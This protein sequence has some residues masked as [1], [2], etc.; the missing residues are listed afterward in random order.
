MADRIVPAFKRGDPNSAV[1]DGA[2]GLREL[3][4]RS[5]INHPEETISPV[6]VD[7]ASGEVV[8]ENTASGGLELPAHVTDNAPWYLGGGAGTL[9]AGGMGVRRWL[10]RRPRICPDCKQP[11][12]LLDE[13]EDD[14]H[15]N[16]GERKEETIGSVDYDVW[17]CGECQ[18]V[19]VERYGAW[20]T[21]YSKCPSCSFKTKK[22]STRT[23]VSATYDHGGSV[24]V[25]VTCKNCPHCSSFTRS[26]P[27]LTR[28]STTSSSSS[29]S[30]FGGGR[31]SG[32]GSS[33]GW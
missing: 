26:T 17:W 6:P 16:D 12:K 31:S 9:F 33:G 30:S 5:T 27:R 10:R 18:D 1:L 11:R 25:T 8:S 3:L 13:N 22:E 7:P 4:D 32:G 14:V 21:S 24:E 15:L 19:Q 29:S 20:L 2:L 23:L 28:P